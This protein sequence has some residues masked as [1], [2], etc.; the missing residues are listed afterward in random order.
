LRDEAREL[1]HQAETLQRRVRLA[2][3]EGSSV[4]IGFMPGLIVTPVVRLLEE[5]WPGLRVD[6]VRTSWTE[7]I[8]A[9]RDG[10][11]DAC[12]A[13]RPFE[14][15][16]LTVV[17]LYAE[18]RVAVLPVGHPKAGASEVRLADLAG[19]LLLQPAGFIPEWRGEVAPPVSPDARYESARGSEG[20][21]RYSPTVEEKLELVAAGRGIVILPA[22]TS[23]YYVRPDVIRARVVDL[24]D[25]EV[26]LVV[27]AK[28]RSDVLRD[29]VRIART[30]PAAEYSGSSDA[31]Q[32]SL[33]A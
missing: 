11:L 2:D 23:R 30:V 8:E 28:R 27:E 19:D 13:R 21:A 15:A 25:T 6:V 1:L 7:Q 17:D 4:R 22:S 26:C 29:L 33:G 12:F 32:A 10:R 24:P 31:D 3:R 16:G 9:L 20:P 14:E 18:P 5:R